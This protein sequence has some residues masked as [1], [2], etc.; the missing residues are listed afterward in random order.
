ML[1]LNHY[2]KDMV[3]SLTQA[4]A[5]GMRDMQKNGKRPA[6]SSCRSTPSSWRPAPATTSRASSARPTSTRS[7]TTPGSQAFI[8]AFQDKYGFPP[9]QA[10]HTAYVQ[11]ILYA[12]ACERAGTFNP[13]EVIKALEDHSR[14]RASARAT[15]FYRGEDHQCFH[16]ILV[17]KGKAPSARAN[18]YDRLEIVKQVPREEVTYDDDIEAFGGPDAELG[19]Y[20]AG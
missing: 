8:T 20:E 15:A 12:D 19:P 16:D 11:T 13:V 4:V 10:A 6:R 9:S 3:N 1:V 5:F 7:W 17:V 14:S 2:G 18:E